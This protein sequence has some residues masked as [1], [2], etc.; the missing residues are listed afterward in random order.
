MYVMYYASMLQCW[1]L[2]RILLRT[3]HPFLRVG[4]HTMAHLFM[5]CIMAHLFL[6]C[7]MSHLIVLSL[8]LTHV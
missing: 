4:C 3:K 8:V 2:V 7:I 5:Y 6:Y 1:Q